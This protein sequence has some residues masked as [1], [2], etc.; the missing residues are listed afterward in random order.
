MEAQRAHRLKGVTVDGGLSIL[1]ADCCGRGQSKVS[2]GDN[3]RKLG[4]AGRWE[5]L[6]SMPRSLGFSPSTMKV[7]MQ[8]SNMHNWWYRKAALG[9]G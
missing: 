9:A 1:G 4:E 5:A 7:Y 8:G 6:K 2:A 3:D